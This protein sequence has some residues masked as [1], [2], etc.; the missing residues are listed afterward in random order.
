MKR[1]FVVLE[2]ESLLLMEERRILCIK[3]LQNRKN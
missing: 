1:M 3:I 2:A